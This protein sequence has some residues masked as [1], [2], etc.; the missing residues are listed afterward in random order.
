M[1]RALTVL[2]WFDAHPLWGRTRT[3]DQRITK[4]SVSIAI[5]LADICSCRNVFDWLKLASE[6]GKILSNPDHYQ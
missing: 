2:A 1:V 3:R 6:L 4:P 5:V